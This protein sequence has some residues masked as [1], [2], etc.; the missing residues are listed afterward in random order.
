MELENVLEGESLIKM[1]KVAK[2]TQ[3][4]IQ[5]VT[6]KPKPICNKTNLR[7]V[8][9]TLLKALLRSILR[10]NLSVFF[11]FYG[12]Y[13]FLSNA[14]NILNLPISQKVEF[15]EGHLLS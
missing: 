6:S 15:V 11:L 4:I 7:K 12:M 8:Q 5:L 14:N 1:D 3:P 2:V 13:N 9:F 10:S